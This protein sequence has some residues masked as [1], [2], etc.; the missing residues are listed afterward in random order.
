MKR[1]TADL[2][3]HYGTVPPWL[4]ERMSLLG[5]AIAEAIIIEYGRPA[6]LQRLSDPFWFQSLG[7]VLGMDWHSSGITTSVMNALRKAINCRSEELGVYI[8]GGRGKFSRETP[9]Q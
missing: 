9:N 3:L 8:C 5:G 2:P 6:L 7:C 4:A 1:G